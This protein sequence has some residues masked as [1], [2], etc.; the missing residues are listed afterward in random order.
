MLDAV[1]PVEKGNIPEVIKLHG[2]H[3]FMIKKFKGDDVHAKFKS[4]L[5]SHGNEP[6]MLL[7]PVRLS[8]MVG[9]HM[10]MMGFIIAS[11][12]TSCVVGKLYIKSVFIQTERTATPMCSKCTGTMFRLIAGLYL[13]LKKCG[14]LYYQCKKA[15][16]HFMAA[17]KRPSC[18]I[19]SYAV[20]YRNWP[21]RSVR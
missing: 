20:S 21:M 17:Y 13:G 19:N 5:V 9:M 2:I 3:L 1:E 10:I 15:R 14:A 7:Y 12:N 18:G 8:P 6:D 16:K 4:Q 11:C